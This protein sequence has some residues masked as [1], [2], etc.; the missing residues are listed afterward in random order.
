MGRCSTVQSLDIVGIKQRH[1][2]LGNGTSMGLQSS[3][4]G[5]QL[6]YSNRL[7]TRAKLLQAGKTM[8]NGKARNLLLH[9][10]PSWA[11][12]DK[13]ALK[14]RTCIAFCSSNFELRIALE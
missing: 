1:T 2:F 4:V 10:L 3:R 13:L 8:K 7:E 11:H 12:E 5:C 9:Q 14:S 6:I